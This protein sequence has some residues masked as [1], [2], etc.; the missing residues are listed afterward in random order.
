MWEHICL[1]TA[2]MCYNFYDMFILPFI[3]ILLSLQYNLTNTEQ[4]LK[5]QKEFLLSQLSFT[6]GMKLHT[7][8]EQKKFQS[9]WETGVKLHKQ[10]K[11][12]WIEG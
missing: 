9:L 12:K 1:G 2:I 8:K 10:T 7:L 6:C 4:N 11:T 5:K 3:K